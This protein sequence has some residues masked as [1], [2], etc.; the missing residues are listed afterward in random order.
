[1][2]LEDNGDV[3]VRVNIP[4]VALYRVSRAAA[5]KI[6]GNDQGAGIPDGEVQAYLDGLPE[7]SPDPQ[8]AGSEYVYE[9]VT[10]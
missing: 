8:N 5:A 6:T 2:T 3:F 10:A 4:G 7:G 1:M 9:K